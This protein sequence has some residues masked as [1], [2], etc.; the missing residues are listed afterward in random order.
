[1][2][3]HHAAVDPMPGTTAAG[4][5]SRVANR[6]GVADLFSSPSE[7]GTSLAAFNT[8]KRYGIA[9][10][11]QQQSTSF[12]CTSQYGLSAR[13][14]KKLA[15]MDPRHTGRN[16]VSW[17]GADLA[18]RPDD[19][20]RS[21]SGAPQ[22]PPEQAGAPPGGGAGDNV[23]ASS[24]WAAAQAGAPK[25]V[26][27]K[28]EQMQQTWA[29]LMRN[30]AVNKPSAAMSLVVR[31]A[32]GFLSF[33]LSAPPAQRWTPPPRHAR[34]LP[35][36]SR[37][38]SPHCIPAGPNVPSQGILLQLDGRGGGQGQP[39]GQ[40]HARDR[41]RGAGRQLQPQQGLVQV[42]VAV[43]RPVLVRPSPFAGRGTRRHG[44]MRGTGFAV[45]VGCL[46]L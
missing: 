42:H 40:Q 12:G 41:A 43:P 24:V 17:E 13:N 27:L 44:P 11:Q 23:T 31:A 34:R 46:R 10:S 6:S 14:G 35:T 1:M 5:F 21:M 29:E 3:M 19:H 15:A 7:Y 8:W 16:P 25:S 32:R 20:N 2:F 28:E 36:P 18:E 37:A 26:P 30:G 9:T 22:L 38:S 45:V 33:S 4:G 39:L